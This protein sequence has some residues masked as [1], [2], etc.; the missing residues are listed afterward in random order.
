MKFELWGNNID[1]FSYLFDKEDIVLKV[2]LED[3]ML[4]SGVDVSDINILRNMFEDGL[5][6]EGSD[7]DIKGFLLYLSRDWFNAL[8]CNN[9]YIDL[10]DCIVFNFKKRKFE[11]MLDDY[12]NCADK[13][14]E[15]YDEEFN[16]VTYSENDFNFAMEVEVNED[17]QLMVAS[18]VYYEEF[19]YTIKGSQNYL[20]VKDDLSHG[21]RKGLIVRESEVENY[22]LEK[23]QM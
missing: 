18:S 20:I 6:K 17:S 3:H 5:K 12:C 14:V 15:T 7:I 23:Q 9:I 13:Y 2:Y 16:L 8:T 21:V 4:I 1:E 10:E 11:S 19:V 22:F